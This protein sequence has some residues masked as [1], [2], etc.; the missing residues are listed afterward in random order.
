MNEEPKNIRKKSWNGRHWLRAWLIVVVVTF[1]IGLIFCLCGDIPGA[2]P[3]IWPELVF[4]LTGSLIM[5]AIFVGLW[6][7]IH[8]LCCWRNFKRFLFGIACFITLI[9]LFYAEEDW[10]GWHAWNQFK[11]KWEAKGERFDFASVIPPPVPDD[12]N[13]AMSP[14]WIAEERYDFQDQPERAKAWYDDRIYSEDVSKIFPLVPVSVSCLVGTNWS[15]WLGLPKTPEISTRWRT[16]QMTDLKPWQ[17]YYRDLE[18]TNPK[19]EIPITPQPQSPAADVLLALSKFAP[20]IERLQQD[21]ALPGARFPIQYDT[22]CP[23]AI[24]LPHLAALKRYAQVLQLRAVAE[25]QNGQSDQALDDVKLALRL[26][27]STR[28]EP[29]LI[30][31]L[32]RIAMLQ[33]MLQPVYEGLAEHKWSDA[34]LVELDSE[35]AKMDFLSDYDTGMHGEMV[36]CQIGDIEYLRRHPE[37]IR[38]LSGEMD[39]SPPVV[40]RIICRLIPNGWFYQNELRCTRPMMEF[41]SLANLDKKNVSPTA[42]R[43]A[44]AAIEAG[45][46]RSNPYNFAERL[47]M[48]ALGNAL[49]KFSWGQESVDLARVAIA[50]ERYRLAHGEYP[51][52]LDALAPQF[53][54]TIPHDII[55]GQPSQGSGPA[56]QPLHYWRTSDGQFVLYSVG[57]NETDDGGVVG[58]N[59]DGRMD[60]NQGDWVWRYPAK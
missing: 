21:S 18:E 23:A 58:F 4:L 39:A 48:P 19:A 26:T 25:L 8:W 29:F 31:H 5:A 42:V 22:D 54:E 2:P 30:T 60:I 24:L 3:T 50:L 55:A 33:I 9:A 32:V 49:R 40:A 17:S 1:F 41:L 53:M 37:Q 11:H 44:D 47:F 43:R 16:A 36:L 38:N 12:Q 57:W 35:L 51:E 7:F 46:K 56:S 20:V 59:K 14:V 27:D 34:Q 28:T 6:A 10:R 15:S 13:F 45:T 52:S